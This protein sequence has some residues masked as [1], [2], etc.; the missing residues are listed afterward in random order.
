LETLNLFVT[1]GPTGALALGTPINGPAW[2]N[3]PTWFIVAA[4]DRI[5][6]PHLEVM[7]AARMKA[8]TI[9]LNTNHVAMLSDPLRVAEFIAKAAETLDAR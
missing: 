9:V 6:S 4:R 1:Q 2:K 8:K 7:E 3:K 5:I